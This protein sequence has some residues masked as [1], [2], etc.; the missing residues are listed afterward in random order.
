VG[1]NK[2]RLSSF[3]KINK[4]PIPPNHTLK[5]IYHIENIKRKK[6]QSSHRQNSFSPPTNKHPLLKT[7]HKTRKH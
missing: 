5:L 4:T 2:Q 1:G 7:E 6:R 3:Q